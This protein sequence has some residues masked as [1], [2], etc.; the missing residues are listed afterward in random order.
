MERVYE[1]PF[2][3]KPR[4][5]IILLHDHNS[6][7]EILCADL[8]SALHPV[9]CD[10]LF[11]NAKFI[12]PT[13]SRHVGSGTATT[14][15]TW[16]LQTKL[17]DTNNTADEEVWREVT[18]VAA[19]LKHL[20][21]KEAEVVGYA[22]VFVGGFG[23]GCA[24]GIAMLLQ[25]E[26]TIGGFIGVGGYM[27]FI[28]D[29]LAMAN[30]GTFQDTPAVPVA[31]VEE[32]NPQPRGDQNVP[33][34]QKQDDDTAFSQD[35]SLQVYQN[36]LQEYEYALKKAEQEYDLARLLL[37]TLEEKGQDDQEYHSRRQQVEEQYSDRVALAEQNYRY[38]IQ[39]APVLAQ[40]DF[41]VLDQLIDPQLSGDPVDPTF[42]DDPQVATLT[43]TSPDQ[44]TDE[45]PAHPVAQPPQDL[46]QEAKLQRVVNFLR[47][48]SGHTPDECAGPNAVNTP[49]ILTHAHEDPKVPYDHGKMLLGTM[50]KL[51]FQA[52]L[53]QV[54]ADEHALTRQML[55]TVLTR[56]LHRKIGDLEFRE[57]I[58]D[59]FRNDTIW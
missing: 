24:I 30:Y 35:E 18:S 38:Q 55:V 5:T 47:A 16:F 27:P 10:S 11:P 50:Q 39:Q 54:L 41:L 23:M 29:I 9:P 1:A 28:D 8:T 6:T 21:H 44:A 12:F 48:F 45:A 33:A 37:L 49:V 14:E 19:E 7:G 15:R 26:K 20:V 40:D 36:A 53:K 57:P 3:G 13:A 51:G 43:N 4:Q 52:T 17:D 42:G 34:A 31:P 2:E 32:Q 58:V 56:I 59:T 46:S 25:L 22:N